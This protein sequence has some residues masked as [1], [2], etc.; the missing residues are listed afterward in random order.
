MAILRG[1][2]KNRGKDTVKGVLGAFLCLWIALGGIITP[3]LT[4]QKS[5]NWYNIGIADA[6]QNDLYWDENC[7]GTDDDDFNRISVMFKHDQKL[8][9]FSGTGS[10]WHYGYTSTYDNHLRVY[11]SNIGGWSNMGLIPDKPSNID[12]TANEIDGTTYCQDFDQDVKYDFYIVNGA[13]FDEGDDDDIRSDSLNISQYVTFA[14]AGGSQGGNWYNEP[15]I[16]WSASC[17]FSVPSLYPSITIN[18]PEPE[19]EWEI[20]VEISVDYDN[21]DDYDLL[22]IYTIGEN[23]QGV[24]IVTKNA[25]RNISGTSGNVYIVFSGLPA[26]NYYLSGQFF[27]TSTGESL[28]AENFVEFKVTK[29]IPSFF[30]SELDPDDWSEPDIFNNETYYET[31]SSYDEPTNFYLILTN[32]I[33]PVANWLSE[34]TNILKT[35]FDREIAKEQG[36]NMAE[37]IQVV[38]YYANI[39]NDLFGGFP[40]GDSLVILLFITILVTIIRLLLGI[41][42]MI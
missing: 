5:L 14:F 41:R 18:S 7:F 28:Y 24:E 6:V 33:N 32:P 10:T 17:D 3:Y 2:F 27:N 9:W 8:C 26:G 38:R 29:Y 4:S 35:Q 37:G 23:D 36:K 42:R 11:L 1:L 30:G 13:S 39:A 40:M 19:S 22:R 21:A 31:V 34:K 20:P 15:E 16:Y 25:T 12:W